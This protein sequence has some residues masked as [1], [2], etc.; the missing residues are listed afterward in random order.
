MAWDGSNQSD[1][2]KIGWL[3]MQASEYRNIFLNEDSHFYYLGTHNTVLGLLNKYLSPKRRALK[4]LD[5]G[6]GT[7][8]LMKKLEK[9]GKVW[10]VD[11]S[12]EAI[13][14]TKQRGIKNVIQSSVEKLPF[15]ENFFD[16]VVSVDVLYH[17]QVE[18]DLH[19]LKEFY[20]VLKPDG[21]L[22]V[23]VP[24][25]NWLRGTHDVVVATRQRYTKKELGRK[26]KQAGL[27][28]RKLS[29]ANMAIFPAAV[30]K[31]LME[32]FMPSSP[33]SDVGVL[34]RYLNRALI[35]I[36]GIE[37]KLMM[38]TGLPFGLSVFAVAQKSE[39]SDN[40]RVSV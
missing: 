37:D 34:P 26:L 22:I 25:F 36:M 17:Q 28:I 3:I 14:F 39:N 38:L 19:A 13:K 6:C 29:Y 23:K 21:F 35:K 5:A 32:R 18:S 11:I 15:Q 30:L 27:K 24:A 7:G 31:R 8:L 10:G 1:N 33:A 4:I 2:Q 40:K 9:F 12:P 16:L 20:R